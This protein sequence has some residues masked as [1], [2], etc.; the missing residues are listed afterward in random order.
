M[1]RFWCGWRP[2]TPKFCWATFPCRSN[3]SIPSLNLISLCL[4]NLHLASPRIIPRG[5]KGWGANCDPWRGRP[6]LQKIVYFAMRE[7]GTWGI[8]MGMDVK[9]VSWRWRECKVGLGQIYWCGPIRR[10]SGFSVTAWGLRKGSAWL[11]AWNKPKG[12]LY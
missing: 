4:K 7:I 8:F 1:V 11:I 12:D 9:G 5:P 2:W 10:D 6:T 3:L